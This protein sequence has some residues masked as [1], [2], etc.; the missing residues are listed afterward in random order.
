[1]KLPVTGSVI[2]IDVG[3]SI[4]RRSSAVCRLDWRSHDLTWTI[5]RFRYDCDDRRRAI[6][7]VAGN[8]RIL[9]AAF[10]G[11]LRR[12]LDLIGR[13]RTAERVL[14]R[15]FHAFIGKPGQSSAP[16]GKR[17]NLAANEAVLAV[18]EDCEIAIASH[19]NPI[20]ERGIVE[21]FPS[22]FMGVML[23]DPGTLAVGRSKKSDRFFDALVSNG[24]LERL[25]NHFLPNRSYVSLGTITNHDDRAGFICALTAMAVAANDFSAVGDDDGWIILPPSVLIAPWALKLL[26]YNAVSSGGTCLYLCGAGQTA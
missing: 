21:A 22:S 10:D 24:G 4:R 6:R 7:L 12:G 14:T 1:M 9:A 25:L 3:F 15:R 19:S 23:P 8:E 11:P 17:L 13:Y 5:E 16:V 20:H 18:L 2:G 26:K